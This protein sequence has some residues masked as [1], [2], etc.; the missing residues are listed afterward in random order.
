MKK[1]LFYI[2]LAISIII[3]INIINILATDFD[4]LTEY[5]YG[6]LVGKVILLLIFGTILLLTRKHKTESKKEL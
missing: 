1:I 4:R 2:S 5:G 3:L 6:Y